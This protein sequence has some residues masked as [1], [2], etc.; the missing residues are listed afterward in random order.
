VTQNLGSMGSSM[1]M[2]AEPT[3]TAVPWV[4]VKVKVKD[5]CAREAGESV[6]REST[7]FTP[8]TSTATDPN[9]NPI[10]VTLPP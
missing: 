7:A 4:R 10:N 2:Q 3:T 8:R 5:K 9:L 1:S 6:D